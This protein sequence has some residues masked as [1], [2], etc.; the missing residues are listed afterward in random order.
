MRVSTFTEIDRKSLDLIKRCGGFVTINLTDGEP[1]LES[2]TQ[3]SKY[4][5]D[6]LIAHQMVIPSG[7]S[8]FGSPP[9]TYRVVEHECFSE[10]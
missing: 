8:L 1:Q 5:L 7:D 6:R 4:R 10:L 3:I 9:Q 2:D